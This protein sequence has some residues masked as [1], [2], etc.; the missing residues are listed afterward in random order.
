MNHTKI[1]M[2]LDTNSNENI[3]GYY[4]YCLVGYK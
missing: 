2:K 1:T 4:N 3:S